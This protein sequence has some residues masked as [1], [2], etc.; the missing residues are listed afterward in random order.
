MKYEVTDQITY[1][2]VYFTVENDNGMVYLISMI[3]NED[4]DDWNITDENHNN[5]EDENICSEL[6]NICE[7]EL[8]K[9]I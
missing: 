9:K 1:K 4:G 8:N 5:I 7:A 3:E 2:T 6:I